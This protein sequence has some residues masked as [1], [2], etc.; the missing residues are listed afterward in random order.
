[1]PGVTAPAIV[2][3]IIRDAIHSVTGN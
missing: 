2:V 3:D 1:M